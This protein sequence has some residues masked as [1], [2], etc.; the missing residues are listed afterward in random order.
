MFVETSSNGVCSRMSSS[1]Q[2][3]HHED[4]SRQMTDSAA[5]GMSDNEGFL[6]PS[7]I[8]TRRTRTYSQYVTGD[9]DE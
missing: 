7:P 6:V 1:Q 2:I 4:D 8:P 9:Y 5:A 3:E